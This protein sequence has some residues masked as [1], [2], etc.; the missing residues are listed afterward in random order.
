MKAVGNGRDSSSL[1]LEKAG[2]GDC[3]EEGSRSLHRGVREQGL[4]GVSAQLGGIGQ[5]LS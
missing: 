3:L 4:P 1:V 2:R 5:E